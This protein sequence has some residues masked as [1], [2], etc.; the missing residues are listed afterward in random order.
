MIDK[1]IPAAPYSI[2]MEK[3]RTL[4]LAV[5]KTRGKA[6]KGGCR[7]ARKQPHYAVIILKKHIPRHG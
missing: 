1:V 3:L 6:E 7:S 2:N 4:V 5:N